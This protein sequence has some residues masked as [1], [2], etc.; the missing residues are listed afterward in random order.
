LDHRGKFPAFIKKTTEN[1]M[2]EGLSASAL[3][4]QKALESLGLPCQVVE[5]PDSTRSAQEAAQAIGCIGGQIVKSSVFHAQLSNRP[6]LVE[7]SGSNR[8]DEERLAGLLNEPVVRAT[9]EFVRESTGFAIGGVPPVGI[10]Q[11]VTTFIDR[12]LMQYGQI[13]AAA[14][15]P[16]AVFQLTPQDL[17][18]MTGGTVIDIRLG[19]SD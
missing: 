11:S 8:V 5:L 3:K 1:A 13:W 17:L 16:N 15:T 12:D 18:R 2:Q 4:V 19:K 10:S 14:G 6:V 7:T 9:P